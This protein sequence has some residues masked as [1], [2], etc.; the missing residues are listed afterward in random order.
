MNS[1]IAGISITCFA[2]SYS[3]TL[4]LEISRMFF[5]SGVRGALM[6]GF[7]SAGF[8][9]HTLYLG[10]R[11]YSAAAS[12][13]SS[14]YDWY[15]VAAWMLVAGY[16]YICYVFPTTSAGIVFLPLA[17]ALVGGASQFA[18]RTPIAPEPAS[19]V[20]AALHGLFLL[21]GAVVVM[22]GFVAGLMYLLQAYRLKHKMPPA[23]GFRFPSLEWLER[24]NSRVVVLS[25]LLVGIGFFAGLILVAVGDTG[26][27][28]PLWADPVV[29]S[30]G[31]MLLWLVVAAA[32]NALYRPA[33]HGNKVAYLTL[34]NFVFLAMVLALFLRDTGLHGGPHPRCHCVRLF[35][36]LDH[37]SPFAATGVE[38]DSPR[39]LVSGPATKKR[40]AL[41]G[42]LPRRGRNGCWLES[43]DLRRTSL[44][45]RRPMEGICRE[46]PAQTTASTPLVDAKSLLMRHRRMPRRNQLF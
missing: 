31:A 34:A 13:L 5:R 18:D 39:L 40:Q 1:L 15:L 20:W 32:F 41:G 3:V 17:L 6:V 9:A 2:S 42:R 28:G 38:R 43:H 7:A 30:S 21:L 19:R 46:L 14:A 8:L 35:L 45:A 23:P 4:A 29:V 44:R 12:P 37:A 16:L 25:A 10:H 27:A 36:A 33:R 24:I 22:I 11:A 26:E